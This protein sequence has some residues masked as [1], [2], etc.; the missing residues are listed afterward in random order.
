VS[1]EEAKS[2]F[3]KL[4]EKK[5]KKDGYTPAVNGDASAIQLPDPGH[6]K[7]GLDVGCKLLT[8]NRDIN[9]SVEAIVAAAQNYWS[10]RTMRTE[11][12]G[13]S[14]T[15]CSRHCE[16]RDRLQP[17]RRAPIFSKRHRTGI[18]IA[19]ASVGPVLLDGELIGDKYIVFDLLEWAGDNYRLSTYDERQ[20]VLSEM[21][22][23]AAPLLKAVRYDPQLL[24]R[25]PRQSF[26]R[27]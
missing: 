20:L 6:K 26:W 4:V 7:S 1:Y 27:N 10:M 2:I 15:H 17:K 19:A 3:D 9:D 14:S 11:K 8:G 5:I 13:R 22:K 12:V 24:V 21:F 16:A 25:K 18:E 23:A